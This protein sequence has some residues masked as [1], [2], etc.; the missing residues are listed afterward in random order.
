MVKG[1]AVVCAVVLAGCGSGNEGPTRGSGE[2][3]SAAEK[4]ALFEECTGEVSDLMGKLKEI[5]SRLDIGLTF[6]EYGDHVSDAKVAYDAVD[7]ESLPKGCLEEVA[8][9]A[10]DALNE[11]IKAFRLWSDCFDRYAC[12]NDTID[13]KL[14][15]RWANASNAID[16]AARGL[17]SLKD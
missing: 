8:T 1:L 13:S 17:E 9:R 5:D 6:D 16:S 2:A 12:S 7:P 14:Q 3:L 4:Q 11:Y 15:A 10:E